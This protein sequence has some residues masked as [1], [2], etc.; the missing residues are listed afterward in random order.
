MSRLFIFLSL[1][2]FLSTGLFAQKIIRS[3]MSCF[4]NI[5]SEN[6]TIFRQTI[7]QSSSTSVFSNDGNTLRQG[8]QQPLSHSKSGF[9]KEKKC[10]LHLTPNPTTDIV[11]ITFSEQIGENTISVFDMM[12][13]LQ[14]QITV[15]SPYYEMDVSNLLNG[16]YN[17]NVISKSGYY[18]SQKLVVL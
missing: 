16:V 4:G 7:G 8:F 18:C 6:G 13:K 14:F 3:S 5:T 15:A 10:S 11:R 17:V 1:F 9:L 12:G 2:T